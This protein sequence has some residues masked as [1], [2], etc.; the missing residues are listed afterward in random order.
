MRIRFLIFIF[1]LFPI[2]AYAYTDESETK[3]AGAR[4]AGSNW[5]NPNELVGVG[6]NTCAEYDNTLQNW[7][8]GY[9][10]QFTG[11]QTGDVIDSFTLG[12]DGFGLTGNPVAKRYVDVAITKDGSV[13]YGD[14]QFDIELTAGSDCS[15]SGVVTLNGL[16][17]W[18]GASWL[19]ADVTGD[20]MGVLI[21][22]ANPQSSLIG[23]DALPLTVWYHTPDVGG[24]TPWLDMIQ[25][26]EG[27]GK[28]HDISDTTRIHHP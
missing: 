15:A 9:Y 16:G 21:R 5:V 25:Q 2:M 19:P 6:D 26:P 10:Y 3:T 4:A 27:A 11:P 23:I 7:I 1:L 24:E 14:I 20:N 17:L 12:L 18:G 13:P 8:S 22:D 28:V